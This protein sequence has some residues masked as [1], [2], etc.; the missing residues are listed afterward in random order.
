MQY[1]VFADENVGTEMAD[2][3]VEAISAPIDF[4]G[5][6]Q[7][8]PEDFLKFWGHVFLVEAKDLVPT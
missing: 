4:K 2:H 8:V 5:M 1:V 7:E 3:L 6:V